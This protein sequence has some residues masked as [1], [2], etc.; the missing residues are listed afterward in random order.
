MVKRQFIPELS[1]FGC[2]FAQIGMKMTKCAHKAVG[3]SMYQQPKQ[4]SWL[5]ICQ[6]ELQTEPQ[7]VLQLMK[8]ILPTSCFVFPSRG[9]QHCNR[10]VTVYQHTNSGSAFS[11]LKSLTKSVNMLHILTK[12]WNGMEKDYLLTSGMLKINCRS[13]EPDHGII[14]R[15]VLGVHGFGGSMDDDIQVGIAEEMGLFYAATVRFDFPAHGSSPMKDL[16]LKGCMESLLAVAADAKQRY[17]E[18]E[19]LCIFATGFGAYVTMLCLQE[20]VQMPGRVKLVVQTPSVRMDETVLAMKGITAQTLRAVDRVTF[21]APRPFE[22]S[23]SFYKELRQN[24]ALGAYPIPMLILQ[25]EADSFIP[26][27]DIQTL[28]RLNDRSKLV[29]IPGASHRFLEDGAWDMV[30]D[31]TRDWFEYEQVLL[32]DWL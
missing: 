31:L 29:I 3:A 30:L 21:R 9:H 28:H 11:W 15:V 27:E 7:S 2:E 19:D 12:G 13:T 14:R 26:I 16:T 20:L 32:S 5:R 10:F 23:Y 24:L 25:G 4:Q 22:V 17:P 1:A 18:V 8:N 6:M